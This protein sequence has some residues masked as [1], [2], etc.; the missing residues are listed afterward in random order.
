MQ[1]IRLIL[2]HEK[3]AASYLSFIAEMRSLGEQIWD[4]VV[5]G[6]SESI[7]DFVARQHRAEIHPEPGL[8]PE[9]FYW[10]VSGDEVVGRIAV[11]HFLN[12]NLEE[13]GGHIGYE[14]RPSVRRRGIATAMLGLVLGE[15]KTKKIGRVLLTCAPD[16]IA[17]N[18]TIQKNGGVLAG[19]KFVE[20]IQRDTNYYWIELN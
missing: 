4:A 6:E 14:V 7:A 15:S 5:P 1:N 9:T 13:F 16:N 18:R 17:S 8:V 11:R 10:A 12:K 19:T 20:R 2:P 3:Y